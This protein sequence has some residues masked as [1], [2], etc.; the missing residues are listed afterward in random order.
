VDILN[1]WAINKLNLCKVLG[2]QLTY[3]S[4]FVPGNDP[5]LAP[6]TLSKGNVNDAI[7]DLEAAIQGKL[8]KLAD[9][10]KWDEQ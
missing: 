5:D 4:R 2:P 6:H 7:R 8:E 1:P 10:V 9:R 3:E